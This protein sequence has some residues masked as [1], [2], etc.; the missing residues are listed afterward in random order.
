MIFNSFKQKLTKSYDK[1]EFEI[2]PI[3]GK[4]ILLKDGA[5]YNSWS[6][7]ILMGIQEEKRAHKNK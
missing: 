7:Q 2:E 1:E 4:R 3:Y 5:L 6:V